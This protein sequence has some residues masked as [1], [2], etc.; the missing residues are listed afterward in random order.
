M[1]RIHE[2]EDLNNVDLTGT[3]QHGFKRKRSTNTAGLLFL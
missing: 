1:Q 2:I 3:S